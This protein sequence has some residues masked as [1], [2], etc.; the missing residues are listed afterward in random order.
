M[1]TD[2]QPT[3]FSNNNRITTIPT[4]IN[5]CIIPR[6]PAFFQWK[7]Y[8]IDRT[9]KYFETPSDCTSMFEIIIRSHGLSIQDNWK[10]LLPTCITHQ[11]ATLFD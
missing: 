1:T 10:R 2:D 9:I 6:G 3:T 8:I 11:H 5:N 7:G 4:K